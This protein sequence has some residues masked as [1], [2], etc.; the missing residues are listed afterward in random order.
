MRRTLLALIAAAL[1]A[2][3][4]AQ[5]AQKAIWGPPVTPAGGSAFPIYRELGVDIFQIQL[6]WDRAAPSRPARPTDP[7]DPAYRWPKNLDD[8]VRLA[9][10]EGIRVAIL[11][12]GAPRW[13]NGNRSSEFAPR[14]PQDY[15][16]FLTAAARRYP[17]V[18][19]WMIWGETNRSAVFRPLP[20]NRPTGPRRYAKLLDAAYVALKRRTR[21]NMVIGGMTFSFGDVRPAH[22][23]RWMRLPSGRMPRLDY[24]G[25]NPFA[26]RFPR[27]S[28][29]PYDRGGRDMSDMDTFSRELRRAYRRDPRHRGRAPKLW[30]S[31][32]TVSSDRPNRAFN[33]AVSRERQ[34]EW[35]TAAFR[36]ADRSRSTIHTMGWYS[37]YDDPVSRPSGLTTG[38]M[39]AEGERKPAFFAYRRAR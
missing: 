31:E 13:T 19:H 20:P 9:R 17:A 7:N 16:N 35:L 11:V 37:L 18:R 5:A 39:T 24:Y 36:I 15:A 33:F 10:P 28:R 6:V 38:L 26:R 34:A 30:L 12:R 29:Q 25:H 8:A 3:A 2:P 1:V 22:Y 21:R 4:S 32:F 14:R 23:V 27:L